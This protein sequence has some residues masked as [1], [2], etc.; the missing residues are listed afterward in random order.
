VL[1]DAAHNPA[2]AAALASYLVSDY[3]S[4]APLVL[5]A[6]RDKDI[7]NM[8]AALLPT[9]SHLILTRASN[10]RSADPDALAEIARRVAPERAITIASSIDEALTIAW[11]L[12]PRIVVAG[13][14]FLLGDVMK[15]LMRS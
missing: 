2:G 1:L 12:S 8:F 4:P 10:S 7:A 3:G 14:I 15:R 5:A 13:S 9:V 6:M 11:R